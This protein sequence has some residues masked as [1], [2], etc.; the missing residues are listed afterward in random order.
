MRGPWRWWWQGLALGCLGLATLAQA[1]Q[2]APLNRPVQLRPGRRPLGEVLAE[3]ARQ[4]HLPLSYSS[5]LVPLSHRYQVLPGPPR[6][7]R[8]VLGEVLASEHLAY[9]LLDGQLVLWPARLAPPPG[10]LVPSG[11][12]STSAA[13]V[14]TQARPLPNPSGSETSA[15]ASEVAR[16][17]GSTATTGLGRKQAAS[18]APILAH[19]QST[20]I[21]RPATA[22]SS[23]QTAV[24]TSRSARVHA[25]LVQLLAADQVATAYAHRTPL[26]P[27]PP[28]AGPLALPHALA[29]QPPASR[30][31]V[32][33]VVSS[34]PAMAAKG[35]VT[36][37]ATTPS[38]ST[39]ALGNQEL[40]L[41]LPRPVALPPAVAQA[42]P[43]VVTG[44]SW[45]VRN[46]PTTN[47][48]PAT[49]PLRGLYLHAEGWT[50]VSLPLGATV[51]VGLPRAYL[52]LGVALADNGRRVGPALGLGLGTAGRARGRFTPSF[53]ALA[54]RVGADRDQLGPGP[55]LLLQLH[56]QLSWQVRRDGR[57][58]LVAGPT[59]N[60]ATAQHRGPQLPPRWDFGRDQW[61]LINQ[62]DTESL[63][64]LWPGVRVGLR[65]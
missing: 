57:L 20:D 30:T 49:P 33:E 43:P 46:Q 13:A 22:L 8:A 35:R 28:P 58:A 14:A 17:M 47:P 62:V 9:G 7:L 29:A 27:V 1:Q 21:R 31:K 25:S 24:E 45:L 37:L 5:S 11:R 12:P 38:A 19:E 64:R 56:P 41:L 39:A 55:V 15:P 54:W 44:I 63:L 40:A 36:P 4:G 10:I 61:L 2:P 65:F 16:R 26:G 32:A 3:L 48:A 52:V 6:P 18:R 59:L 34:H 51:K 60:L 42:L 23:A 53:D 50:S